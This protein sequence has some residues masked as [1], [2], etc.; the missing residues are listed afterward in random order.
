MRISGHIV[1]IQQKRIY[2]GEIEFFNGVIV[3]ILQKHDVENQFIMPGFIDAHVHI[4]SSM[5]T[6][7]EFARMAVVH[8][9][10][11]TISDPHEI[12]NVMGVEGVEYMIEDGKQVPFKF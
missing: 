9:T 12:G 8:G 1:D 6:P 11:A 4:E 3:S 7:S 5:V 10:I 2:D